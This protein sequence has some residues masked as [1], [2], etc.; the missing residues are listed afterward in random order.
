M[1]KICGQN[2]RK[3]IL[4]FSTV[5]ISSEIALSR[6]SWI[7]CTVHVS[8]LRNIYKHLST[9]CS[10]GCMSSKIR[11]LQK[12]KK[13]YPRSNIFVTFVKSIYPLF[14][15]S[16]FPER[17]PPVHLG[18]VWVVPPGDRDGRREGPQGVQ[19]LWEGRQPHDWHDQEVIQ[20]PPRE[21]DGRIRQEL[22][23]YCLHISLDFE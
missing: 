14:L 8:F 4:T 18:R 3:T 7:E 21:T 5:I 2:P 13:K 23:E 19:G 6:T 20:E 9:T 16:R 22:R 17:S 12:G 11:I 10:C 15:L 1:G